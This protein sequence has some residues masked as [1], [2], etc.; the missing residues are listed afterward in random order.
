[1]K[2]VRAPARSSGP[3]RLRMLTRVAW[4]D[5]RPP[6]QSAGAA[7]SSM[8]VA[9]AFEE[10]PAARRHPWRG[11]P[12]GD[13]ETRRPGALAGYPHGVALPSH[14]S[15]GQAAFARGWCVPCPTAAA[16]REARDGRVARAS[17]RRPVHAPACAEMPTLGRR[18][19]ARSPRGLS[20][21]RCTLGSSGPSAATS[22]LLFGDFAATR[23]PTRGDQEPRRVIR[24]ALHSRVMTRSEETAAVEAGGRGGRPALHF[25]RPRT[26]SVAMSRSPATTLPNPAVTLSTSTLTLGSQPA[27]T[28]RR[29]T[30]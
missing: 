4:A 1:M 17:P 30:R 3:T 18:P 10:D 20:A 28:R 22:L 7:T 15:R 5:P 26:P 6:N 14:G 16:E 11:A 12:R 23:T 25:H 9:P 21:W 19:E 13:V 27:L 8:D 2:S 24:I 29:S